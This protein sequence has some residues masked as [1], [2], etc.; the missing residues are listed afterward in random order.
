MAV[1]RNCRGGLRLALLRFGFPANR[2]INSD[3][4]RFSVLRARR[5]LNSVRQFNGLSLISLT[6]N[7][8]F[9]GLTR[10][11]FAGNGE[12]SA[13]NSGV[14][15]GRDPGPLIRPEPPMPRLDQAIGGQRWGLATLG[16]RAD[17]VWR[18]EGKI[19]EMS[20]AALGDALTVGDRR[21]VAPAL[22][23]SNETQPRATVLICVRSKADGVLAS[24]S[25]ASIPRRRSANSPTSD[26]ALR[27]ICATGTPSR[28]AMASGRRVIDSSPGSMRPPAT[29][30]L[31]VGP[32]S[33]PLSAEQ[34]DFAAEGSLVSISGLA[35]SIRP[36]AADGVSS[37][38]MIS[39][40][41]APS[42][43]AAGK[44]HPRLSDFPLPAMSRR[45]T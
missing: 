14:R 9:F 38:S 20:D 27:L 8:D 1:S 33:G 6:L 30:A 40:A 18:Q 3:P 37:A 10:I 43:A 16:D 15:D 41:T 35:P 45:E 17:N 12:F 28:S 7:R 39:L 36:W 22:I 24:T 2:V 19:H 34:S 5:A 42:S 26:S 32:R 31:R 13:K 21:M 44:R 4:G 11:S 23:S 29:I 25:F